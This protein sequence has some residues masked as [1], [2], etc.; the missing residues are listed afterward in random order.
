MIDT[1]DLVLLKSTGEKW[2]VCCVHEGVVWL[3]QPGLS[4]VRLDDLK[5]LEAATEAQRRALLTTLADSSG[6]GHRP[7]CARERLRGKDE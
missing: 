3:N 7:T 6:K 2:L 5:L 1:G 4:T